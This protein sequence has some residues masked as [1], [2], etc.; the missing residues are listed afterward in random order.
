[1]RPSVW[2]YCRDRQREF[3]WLNYFSVYKSFA[4]CFIAV[5]TKHYSDRTWLERLRKSLW[6]IGAGGGA[7]CGRQ[8]PSASTQETGKE[9]EKHK[10]H[11][12]DKLL[13][14]LLFPGQFLKSFVTDA[15]VNLFLSDGKMLWTNLGLDSGGRIGVLAFHKGFSC[16]FPFSQTLNLLNIRYSY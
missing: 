7:G 3:S 15:L 6:S 1:M 12:V 2:V 10:T 16:T 5:L 9:I 8:H 4:P 11:C 14:P 13:D